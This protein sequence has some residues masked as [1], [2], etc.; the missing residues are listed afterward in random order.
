MSHWFI[1]ANQSNFFE[2]K[3]LKSNK[4]KPYYMLKSNTYL[5]NDEFKCFNVIHWICIVHILIKG[6]G[7]QENWYSEND[8]LLGIGK[9]NLQKHCFEN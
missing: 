1:L 7:P 3:L 6:F 4:A 2:F 8:H 5:R 9:T